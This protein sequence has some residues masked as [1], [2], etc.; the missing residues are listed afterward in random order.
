[1]RPDLGGMDEC[2]VE[3]RG[4]DQGQDPRAM[5]RLEEQKGPGLRVH[6]DQQARA[7]EYAFVQ[8]DF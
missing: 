8:H 4:H 7:A 1:M 5:L 2:S 3:S 6:G